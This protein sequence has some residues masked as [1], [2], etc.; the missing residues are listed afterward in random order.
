M[1]KVTSNHCWR[2]RTTLV[3]AVHEGRVPSETDD[4]VDLR[5]L[6]TKL[7]HALRSDL[8]IQGIEQKSSKHIVEGEEKTWIE[9]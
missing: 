3:K 2:F 5:K 1:T 4:F 6:A 7:E 8:G 9:N